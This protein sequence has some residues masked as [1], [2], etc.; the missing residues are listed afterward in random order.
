MDPAELV[1][2]EADAHCDECGHDTTHYMVAVSKHVTQ[3]TCE[4][5][6][7]EWEFDYRDEWD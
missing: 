3:C 6:G 2:W 1:D 4:T 7:R 5:C